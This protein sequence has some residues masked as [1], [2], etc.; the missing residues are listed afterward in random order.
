M[1]EGSAQLAGRETKP[2]TTAPGATPLPGPPTYQTPL[3]LPFDATY[4]NSL[5]G[6]NTG[7]QNTLADADQQQ[8]GV[9]RSYGLDQGYTPETFGADPFSRLA[10]LQR[11]FKQRQQATTNQYASRQ[12][13]YAGSLQNAQEDNSRGYLGNYDS[14]RKGEEASLTSIN[15]ARLNARTGAETQ[16]TDALNDLLTRLLKSP[17]PTVPAPPPK[18]KAPAAPKP[19]AKGKKPKHPKPGREK[20]PKRGRALHEV[21]QRIHERQARVPPHERAPRS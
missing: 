7:L 19:P 6:I 10:V 13:L 14:L 20:P 21:V 15:R 9:Q 5:L 4:E 17:A 11:S 1:R 8:R 18:P 12:Q 2:P 16:R 3:G